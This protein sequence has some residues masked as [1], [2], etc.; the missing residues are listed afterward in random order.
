MRCLRP[1]WSIAITEPLRVDFIALLRPPGCSCAAV[2]PPVRGGR[3]P[4][5][6]FHPRQPRRAGLA[7]VARPLRSQPTNVAAAWRFASACFDQCE[8]SRNDAD[9]ARVR[10]RGHRRLPPGACPGPQCLPPRIIIWAWTWPNWPAPNCSARSVCWA[11]W[12]RSG[13][14]PSSSTRILIMPARTGIS[15]CSIA[16]PRAGR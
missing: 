14:R 7:R 3:F 12:R 9:R 1:V 10:Q 16:T 6:P 13:R 8:F 5:R 11:R 15:A 2:A 4:G